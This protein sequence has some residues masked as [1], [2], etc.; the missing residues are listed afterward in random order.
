MHHGGA[1]LSEYTVADQERMKAARR[2]FRWKSELVKRELGPRVLEVGCGLGNFSDHLREQELVVG[3]DVEEDCVARW[4]ERFADR[5]HYTSRVIN[6][7]SDAFLE[8]RAHRVDSI[9]CLNVLEHIED[10]GRA[11]RNMH[12]VL[13]RGGRAVLVVPAFRALYGEI[14]ARLGH[15]RRYTR[16]LVRERAERSGFHVRRLHFLNTAGFFGWWMNAKVLRLEKQSEWQIAVFDRCVVPVMSR[17]EN[18]VAPPF[19]QSILAV[20]EKR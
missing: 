2:Y 4:R 13:P 19:G 15:Q 14:D 16:G 18:V 8:L 3:I 20:L 6:A 5:P 11:L 1:T 9:A 7:E 17:L 12:S 10:D